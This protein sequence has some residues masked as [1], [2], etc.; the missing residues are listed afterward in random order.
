VVTTVIYFASLMAGG[1]QLPSR[2]DG[3][4]SFGQ[5]RR[6]IGTNLAFGA[7]SQL[8]SFALPGDRPVSK[9]TGDLPPQPDVSCATAYYVVLE[10]GRQA[11]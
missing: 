6:S 2:I 9:L 10:T 5:Y 11:C 4:V 7:G 8:A 3:G 1:F